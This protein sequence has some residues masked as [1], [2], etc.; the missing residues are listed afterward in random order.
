MILLRPKNHQDAKDA[1]KTRERIW[2]AG[3]LIVTTAIFALAACHADQL[4]QRK[5]DGEVILNCGGNVKSLDPSLITDTVS[6]RAIMVLQRGLTQLDALGKPYPDLAE[7]WTV[8]EDGRVYDIKLRSSRWTN[9]QPVTAEDF[10]YAWMDRMLKP[11]F[12]S[13]YAYML[14]YIDGAQDF[15]EGKNKDRKSV[16]VEVVAP[17]HLRVRLKDPISFFPELMAHQSYY[18]ICKSADRANPNWALQTETY[19]GNGPFKLAR[20]ATGD[21]L[22]AEKFDG[23]WNSANVGLKKVTL[24]F[25]D[26]EATERIAFENHE[27][28]ATYSAPRPDL[29]QLKKGKSLRILPQLG[30]YF[31]VF[32]MKLP[33]FADVR[34]RRALALAID[35][36][37]IVKNVSRAGEKAALRFVPPQLYS[38]PPDDFFKDAQFEEA[39]RLMADAGYPD[40]KGFPKIHYLYNTTDLHEAIAQV[41]QENWKKNLGVEIALENQEFKVVVENRH[42]GNFELA[43]HGWVADLADPINFLEI[44]ISQSGNNDAQWRDPKYDDLVRNVRSERDPQKRRQAVHDAENYLMEN[45]PIIPIYHYT[46]PYLCDPDLEGYDVSPMM[47]VDFVKVRWRNAK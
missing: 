46:Q 8:S 20:F 27:L 11:E 6:G 4:A 35:R 41:L 9:G 10:A 43:R 30:T 33:M 38:G 17:D 19:V 26:T 31:L 47:T 1:K 40:G 36:E 44:F 39:R 2:L 21:A 12:G 23:Y 16:G 45:M 24:R 3:R 37:A 25:I 42:K 13:E 28:D 34:V 18:A 14:Y 29:D 32:N 5:A 22:V 15:Y 7:S